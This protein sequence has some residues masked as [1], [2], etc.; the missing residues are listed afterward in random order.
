MLKENLHAVFRKYKI[1]GFC[2]PLYYCLPFGLRFVIGEEVSGADALA[3]AEEIFGAAF[4]KQNEM[5]VVIEG[6]TEPIKALQKLSHESYPVEIFDED[7]AELKVITRHLFGGKVCT[8]PHTA[9]L[10][11]IL[12]HPE[13]YG[14]RIYFVDTE[15]GIMMMLY[16]E[17]GADVVAP[18]AKLLSPIYKEKKHILSLID[19]PNMKLLFED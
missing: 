4:P 2:Y 14:S 16:D 11:A 12:K 1:D 10:D 7:S 18:S 9:L 8:V 17:Q 6:D 15:T 5:L 3:R 13:E 19:L